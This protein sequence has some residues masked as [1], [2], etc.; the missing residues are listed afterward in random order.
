MVDPHP[1][2]VGEV[3]SICKKQA[4]YKACREPFYDEDPFLAHVSLAAAYLCEHCYKSVFHPST[5]YE[6]EGLMP[7]Y[8]VHAKIDEARV[9][10]R[11]RAFCNFLS[12]R[13]ISEEDACRLCNG[14]G[15]RMYS[16]TST[17]RGG[18]GGQALTADVCDNCWGSG[19]EK[20]PWVN[21]RS[22]R[23]KLYD[24]R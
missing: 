7:L 14:A 13:G 11:S 18:I 21:L 10:E 23:D 20:R 1:Q 6:G 3:C 9:Q 16:N 8:E 17:W 19:D 12:W 2:C 5:L 15:S 22:L 24:E 4:Y